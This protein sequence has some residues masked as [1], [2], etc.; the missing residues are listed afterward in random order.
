[1][2]SSSGTGF[3]CHQCA[4]AGG[5]DPFKKPAVPKKRKAPE[6]K[7]NVT[8]FEERRFPTLVNICIQVSLVLLIQAIR[9]SLCVG[10]C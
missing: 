2:A 9:S 1:M 3:L 10:I 8:K 4:K 6:E 7:R 5:V